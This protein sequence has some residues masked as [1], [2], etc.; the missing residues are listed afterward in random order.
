MKNLIFTII[1][2][3]LTLAGQA[4]NG[5]KDKVIFPRAFAFAIDDMGWNNGSNLGENGGQ[6]PYRAG[7]NKHMDINDYKAVVNVGKA[8]GVR[9]Q[10]L[11]VLCE[12]DRTNICAKYP[13]TTMYGSDWDNSK[14]VCKE[15][16][17]IME[18]IRENA[19]YLEFG[20]HGV[21]HEFWPEK[22]KKV[23]AEWYDII[24]NKPWPE[25]ELRGHIECFKNI[26]AQYGLTS[27]N[28]QSFPKSF[29]PC[30][31][32]YYWNPNGDYSLG[33]LLNENGVKY[34]NTLFSWVE[35]LNPPKG[36]NA[37]GFD[38]GV[39]VINR[40]N[41][42]NEWYHLSALPTVALNEQMSDIIETHW[43]NWLAQDS[44]LQPTVTQNFINYYK[45]V[46]QAPDRYVAKNTEQLHSQ[47]LYNNYTK[48]DEKKS[49]EV[50]IDNSAMPD[51][52]YT[53]KL[54]G[55]MVLKIKLEP[56]NHIS[57]ASI[58]N[59]PI[60]CYFEDEGFG[61]MYLPMLSQKI[62]SLKYIVSKNEMPVYVYNDG[63]YNVY[64][65]TND[66]KGLVIDLSLYG[67]QTVKIHCSN[68]ARV[69]SVNKNIS[70]V[71][72]NYDGDK[73][74]LL[75]NLSAKDMQGERGLLQISF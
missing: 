4:Q 62:Y 6:G 75:L 67:S 18:Y 59:N 21:G 57:S 41:Y 54:L 49:G 39:H 56:G 38:H 35:E 27:E 11:F 36:D 47:W 19:A 60:A 8:I 22:G 58:D 24:N 31:Y 3:V 14:N 40:V 65:F 33:K 51:E 52:V 7:V 68:P 74:I 44:F 30:A 63:T 42:G 46:Q 25:A 10:G 5:K 16:I 48:V 70:I 2:S 50:T 34:A 1:M 23:R 64:S 66:N 26:M 43:P 55:N 45:M 15:Q 13:T 28:G 72:Q 53:N 69:T 17:E 20:F 37:G 9:V 29:V 12:M 73:K 71:N 61:F 32:S